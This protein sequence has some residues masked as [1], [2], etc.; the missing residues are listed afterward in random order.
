M[1]FSTIFLACSASAAETDDSPIAKLNRLEN[2]VTEIFSTDSIIKGAGRGRWGKSWGNRWT[3]KFMRSSGRIK[4]SFERCGTISLEADVGFDEG[5]DI[6]NPC[7]AIKQ[8]TS[9]LT[10]WVNRHM[11]SCNDQK[12]HSHNEKR[13][14]NWQNLLQKGIGFDLSFFRINYS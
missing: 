5:Y 13:M 14:Q 1:K 3:A 6:E 4:N 2:I 12:N 8:L 9:G 10:N 11:S 7:R